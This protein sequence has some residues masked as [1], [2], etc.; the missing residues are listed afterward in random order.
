MKFIV[1]LCVQVRVDAPS[2]YLAEQEA[3][4]NAATLLPTGTV[5]AAMHARKDSCAH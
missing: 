5:S 3:F 2:E 4:K 1:T